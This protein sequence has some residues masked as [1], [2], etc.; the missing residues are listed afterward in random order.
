MTKDEKRFARMKQN[1]KN[2]KFREFVVAIE[3]CG[4][5]L[6]KQT[7]SHRKYKHPKVP[8]ASLV[9]QPVAGNAMP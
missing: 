6:V 3:S 7:G 9:V 2:V 4:W 5:K 1:P 8:D